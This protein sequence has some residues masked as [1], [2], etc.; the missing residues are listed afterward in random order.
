MAQQEAREE[1]GEEVKNKPQPLAMKHSG[2]KLSECANGIAVEVLAQQ[3]TGGVKVENKPQPWTKDSSRRGR[4]KRR[5]RRGRR[6]RRRR[7]RKG[8]S[9]PPF[10]QSVYRWQIDPNCPKDNVQGLVESHQL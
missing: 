5:K 1:E 4:R 9:F 10:F 2:E 6:R 3:G 7:R 8:G